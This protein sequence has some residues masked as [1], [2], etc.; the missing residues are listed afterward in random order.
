MDHLIVARVRR[1]HGV[2]GEVLVAL[3]TD[4]PR[5]V[6]RSGAKL[7]LGDRDGKPDG[8][9]VVVQRMRPTT[10]GAILK[11]QGIEDRDAVDDLR[12]RTMLIDASAAAPAAADEVHYQDLIGLSAV[13]G[14]VL[15]GKVTDI[16]ELP[17]GVM[18]VIRSDAGKETLVPVVGP[19]IEEVDLSAR[20]IKLSLPD[21]YL[22]I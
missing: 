3:E 10:G 1:P 22:E 17:T 6:F 13:A 4:R 5:E 12:G 9:G 19:L 15:V 7:L 14:D 11:L 21:G 2:R 18:L 8:S 16:M 20:E